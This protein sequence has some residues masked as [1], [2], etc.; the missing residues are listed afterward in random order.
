MS[1]PTP[2]NGRLAK[3]LSHVAAKEPWVDPFETLWPYGERKELPRREALWD[4]LS[5]LFAAMGWVLDSYMLPNHSLDSLD[6]LERGDALTLA[7]RYAGSQPPEIVG[8]SLRLFLYIAQV[9]PVV[10]L[11]RV[12]DRDL[13]TLRRLQKSHKD[14]A[15]LELEH[16]GILTEISGLDE[17]VRKAVILGLVEMFIPELLQVAGVLRRS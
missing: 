16:L 4:T 15:K 14:I 12:R 9:E 17:D 11:I 6:S 1:T 10:A 3:R 2:D 5:A 7:V 13:L 8:D